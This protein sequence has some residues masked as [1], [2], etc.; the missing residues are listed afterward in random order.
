MTAKPRPTSKV[1]DASSDAPE[2]K[3]KASPAGSRRRKTAETPAATASPST[4]PTL[5]VAIESQLPPL[6]P[7]LDDELQRSA[8]AGAPGSH[9]GVAAVVGVLQEIA[10]LL[11]L[12]NANSFKVRA[13]ENAARALAGVGEDLATLIPEDRLQE[14]PGIGDSIAEKV[15][16]LWR[17]GHMPYLDELRAQVPPG[18]LDMLRIPGLGPK[19]A[20]ALHD[21]LGIDSVQALELVCRSGELAELKGFGERTA[22]NI[23]LG[24]EQMRRVHGVFPWSFAHAVVEPVLAALRV[25]PGVVRVEA[26]GSLRRCK[27]TVHDVD[28]LVAARDPAAVS[29]D[30]ATGPWAAR[31]LGS[32]ETKTSVVHP[33]GLQMDLRVVSALQFPY[34]LHHFTGSK[35]H[36]IAMRGRAVRMGYKMNEYGLFRGDEM[37]P[38]R[39]EAQI[40][41]ALGLACVPP[42][43]REDQGEIAAA[44]AGTLPQ[45]LIE[46]ADVRGTLHVHTDAADGRASLTD[47]CAA[48]QARG[49]QYLGICDH[50]RN[51]AKPRGLDAAGFAAQRRAIAA[52]P[53][54]GLHV[55]HGVEV[56]VLPDGRLDIADDQLA[57]FDFVIAAVHSGFDLDHDAQTRRLLKAI[58]YPRVTVLAHPTGRILLHREPC[59][60]DWPAVFAAAVAAGVAVEITCHPQRMDMDGLLAKQARDHGALVHVGPDAHDV[61]GLDDMR[62][63]IGSARRA[64][65]EPRQVLN[66]WT[67][68]EVRAHV[69]SRR[70]APSA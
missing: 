30:F 12:T 26:A 22:H 4:P 65:L 53:S 13:Y 11:Q 8:P 61:A 16:T 21:G 14:V 27:E 48:A 20:Q 51:A 25:H 17:T 49:W 33:S 46:T 50:A 55:F 24:I 31:V 59:E 5:Q 23:L 68:E 42:E 3:S 2:A 39:D 58:A 36:N 7:E 10:A 43:L 6:A 57:A 15:A 63:G 56:D 41:A 64:W 35:E 66:T 67:L 47:L 32:G 29:H 45:Q 54:Q 19:R 69:Q 70:S 52:L 40:F 44:E 37:V 60:A 38:C 9:L 28:L 34:A 62:L 1:H 18:L